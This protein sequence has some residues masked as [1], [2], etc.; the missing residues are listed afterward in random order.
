MKIEIR[1]G[2]EVHISGY[3]NAVE[4][5]SRVLPPQMARN[6]PGP[7]VEKVSAGAFRMAIAKNPSVR[8]M[9]N[10]E[11]DLSGTLKLTED[12]IGLYAELTTTDSEVAAAAAKGELRGWSF[13]F[14]NAA[15][16]WEPYKENIQ[17]RTLKT[18]DLDEVSVL[19]KI[20]AYFGTSVEV[21]SLDSGDQ[22]AK[23]IRAFDDAPTE[24][25]NTSDNSE[26]RDS[27]NL[28]NYAALQ[29]RRLEIMTLEGGNYNE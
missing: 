18:F 9:F 4:R 12:N 17:R 22:F 7:F 28:I 14:V 5:D 29:K 20:P 26:A 15:D 27:T 1:S 24:L 8:A 6:A 2:G 11:R 25:I 19:T 21:R 3:V 10:H 16:T 23:E 13:G